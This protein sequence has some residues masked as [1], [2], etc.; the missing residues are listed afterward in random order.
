MSDDFS[1]IMKS[2]STFSQGVF[3]E[4]RDYVMIIK[5]MFQEQ[6]FFENKDTDFFTD[7]WWLPKMQGYFSPYKLDTEKKCTKSFF[8]M[9]KVITSGFNAHYRKSAMLIP[10]HFFLFTVNKTMDSLRQR[11]KRHDMTDAQE[12]FHLIMNF[13][14]LRIKFNSGLSEIEIPQYSWI[15]IKINQN[16]QNTFTLTPLLNNQ[17][18]VQKGMFFCALICIN[19][20]LEKM[21]YYDDDLQHLHNN[22]VENVKQPGIII[23]KTAKKPPES[24]GVNLKEYS[25]GFNKLLTTPNYWINDSTDNFVITENNIFPEKSN[26]MVLLLQSIEKKRKLENENKKKNNFNDLKSILFKPENI[27]NI[28]SVFFVSHKRKKDGNTQNDQDTDKKKAKKNEIDEKDKQNAVPV[29]GQNEDRVS[30]PDNQADNNQ[31]EFEDF[32]L[33]LPVPSDD[34][35]DNQEE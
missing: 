18:G 16:Q 35:D 5:N 7:V 14:D 4:E 34:D 1:D 17:Q 24:T 33:N 20:V 28:V 22:A 15:T 31:A 12:I 32:D 21:N 13:S 23:I 11:Y 3:K 30:M 19:P 9:L 26:S 27:A 29:D 25:T 10:G 8:N 2:D 6:E